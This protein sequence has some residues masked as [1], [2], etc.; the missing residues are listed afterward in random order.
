MEIYPKTKKEVIVMNNYTIKLIKRETYKLKR[1][2]NLF[3][4]FIKS[5]IYEE[6]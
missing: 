6:L 5:K 4:Y 2:V 3:D 1:C